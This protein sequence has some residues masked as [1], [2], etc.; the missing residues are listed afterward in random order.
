VSSSSHGSRSGRA[1]VAPAVLAWAALVALLPWR[2]AH[3][4][5]DPNSAGPIYQMLFPLFIAIATGLAAFRRAL[6]RMWQ[7]VASVVLARRSERAPS[8]T[9]D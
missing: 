3:A 9:P 6:G 5:I 4:Y 7:R 8:R 2:N 1:A